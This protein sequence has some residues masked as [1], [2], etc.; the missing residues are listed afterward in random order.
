MVNKK[1]LIF[2]LLCALCLVSCSDNPESEEISSYEEVSVTETVTTITAVQTTQATT[3]EVTTTVAEVPFYFGDENEVPE[4]AIY[5]KIT[6][7]YRNGK[8][9]NRNIFFYDEHDNVILI[10]YQ[11]NPESDKPSK[12]EYVY[13]YN[14][15]GTVSSEDM[16][17]VVGNGNNEH[18]EYE[19]DYDSN[20][21]IISETKYSTH[22]NGEVTETRIDYE[23]DEQDRVIKEIH[24]GMTDT[25]YMYDENGNLT[26]RKIDSES[27]VTVTSYIY[28][29]DNRIIKAEDYHDGEL[30]YYYEYEYE[31]Y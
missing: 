11:T 5:K 21:N 27:G 3:A 31:F 20:G 30:F 13:N 2:V 25:Y 4:N 10:L 22:E 12:I 14:A 18:T 19:Y 29:K 16:N 8:F 28:D 17:I 6:K 7:S 24:H 26:E 9:A 23:Y 15:D 1:R